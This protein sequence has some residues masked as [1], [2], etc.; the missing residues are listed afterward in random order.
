MKTRPDTDE[1]TVVAE[2]AV[3]ASG[4]VAAMFRGFPKQFWLQWS[5]ILV[6]RLGTFVQPFLLLYL[7][8][9]RHLTEQ[10]AG[11]IAATWGAGVLIGPLLGGWAADRLG[12]RNTMVG[13]MLLAALTLAA[14]GCARSWTSLLITAFLAGVAADIYRPASAALIADI[15][16]AEKRARAYGLIFWAINLGFSAASALGGFLA[17]AGYTLLFAVDAGTCAIFAVIMFFFVPRD[18]AVKKEESDSSIGYGAVLRNRFMLA[19]L[20]LVLVYATVY[21][22][23]YVTLPLSIRDAGLPA[24]VYGEVIAVNGVVIVLFQP[25]I[26]ARLERYNPYLVMGGAA[27][28]LCCGLSLT[29]LANTPLTFALTVVAWSFGEASMAGVPQAIVAQAAPAGA[30][31]KYQG[32][33]TLARSGSTLTGPLLGTAVYSGVGHGALWGGC[34]ALGF[35]L[36]FGY[37]LLRRSA[38]SL[39]AP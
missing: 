29:G 25:W 26:A 27:F 39:D 22:Q 23:A 2:E 30:Q 7:T 33:F 36:L 32:A 5:G 1:R 17:A 15:I 20:A 21:E 3:G 8:N 28:L 11:V 24:S 38:S 14:L 16:P 18:V 37:S 4:R 12:R 13:G 10:Q 9:V 31:G 34:L 19:L 35:I 6:N